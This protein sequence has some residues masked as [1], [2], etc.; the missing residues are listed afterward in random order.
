MQTYSFA[1]KF[2]T[3]TQGVGANNADDSSGWKTFWTI[4][5]FAGAASGVYYGYNRYN[6]STAYAIGGGLLGGLLPPIAIPLAV[7]QARG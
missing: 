2:N 3:P 6:Q 1:R 4:L 7:M 5:T